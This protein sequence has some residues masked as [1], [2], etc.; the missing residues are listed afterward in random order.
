MAPSIQFEQVSKRYRIGRG[1]PSLRGFLKSWN[2]SQSE[3]FHWAIRNVSFQ[4]QSGESLGIIGPNGAGKTTILKLLS[5]VT[6]PTSGK[7]HVTGRSSALI[8]LGAG[9][10]PDLTGRENIYLNGTILGMRRAEIKARF[11]QIVDFA[12]I[13]EYLDTPVKRYSSGMYARLGFAIAAHVDPEVLLVDE[14]LAVGDYAFRMK[15][16]ERMDELRANGTLLI[17][18][19][20]N[21]RDVRRV[22]D[23]G[24]VM[25]RGEKAFDG[26]A[27][28]ATAEYAN[29]LRRHASRF[30]KPTAP[31]GRGLRQRR[32]THAARIEQVELI[33]A[34]GIPKRI[35]N[36][37]ETV[38]IAVEVQFFEHAESPVFA[39]T[40]HG[41]NGEVVYDTTTRL[42]GIATP[43]YRAGDWAVVTYKLDTHL[44]DGAYHLTTDLAYADLSC[45]YDYVVGALSFVVIGGDKAKGVA[46]LRAEVSFN[47]L[48]PVH[49]TNSL[50]TIRQKSE[51]KLCGS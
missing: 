32:M 47:T 42:L 14:V 17:F 34:D 31:R 30:E 40:I 5:R 23:R 35:V 7:I 37:G 45:Y 36:S 1:I 18:V 12:G 33:G 21:M 16:Y 51:E 9:F 26:S 27:A 4:L 25:Y 15:C 24:I 50:Q 8:E 49:E 43:D 28:E 3:K 39:C 29:V 20:H 19:S 48:S 6:H 44:L 13:G 41:D 46:N 38:H 22:C 2:N 10:H 11:D